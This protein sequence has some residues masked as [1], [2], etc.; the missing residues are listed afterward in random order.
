[1][2]DIQ[3]SSRTPEIPW[4]ERDS[5]PLYESLAVT[6]ISRT[7]TYAALA[8]GRLT[9]VKLGRRTY[10]LTDSIKALLRNSPPWQPQH[11]GRA[12]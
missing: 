1:M 10:I 7:E 6:K 4:H 2:P 11:S 3:D 5:I 12:A 9:G 8:D